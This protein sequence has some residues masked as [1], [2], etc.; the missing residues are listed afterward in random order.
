MKKIIYLTNKFG[1]GHI[2]AAEAVRESLDH[3]YPGKYQHEL[4]DI[5][6]VGNNG[7][8]KVNIGVNQFT[9]VYA[10]GVQKAAFGFAD[11]YENVL[12]KLALTIARKKI[13]K[14]IITEKPDLIIS[15]FGFFNTTVAE[16]LRE[17]KHQVPFGTLVT[18]MG[19]VHRGWS[20]KNLDFCLVPTEETGYYLKRYG[21][22]PKKIHVFGFPVRRQ[23]RQKHS[24]AK[25]AEKYGLDLNRKTI[26]FFSGG[27]G[28][29]KLKE[30]VEKVSKQLSNLQILVLCGYNKRL[31]KEIKTIAKRTKKNYIKAFSY[32]PDIA[33]NLSIADLVI[34]KAGGVS[35]NELI[36][37]K[38]PMIIYEI[39]PGQE[40]P[41]AQFVEHMGFGYIEKKPKDLVDR[42]KYI[43]ET[44]DDKRMIKNLQAYS[45]NNQAAEK[46]AKFL[47]SQV[48]GS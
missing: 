16:V 38:K 41:N 42:I 2:N 43:F 26:V 8:Y 45:S 48:N 31:L 30:R 12:N 29:G 34:T 32:N 33:E 14:V 39:I 28:I 23:F 21:T 17:K 37:L 40:E 10:K 4:V 18:D 25:V 15:V 13:W 36:A 11:K 24:K 35:V 1:T 7:L 46:I 6:E 47:N 9:S 44:D 22:D 27:L 5:Y 3:L 19:K 20:C